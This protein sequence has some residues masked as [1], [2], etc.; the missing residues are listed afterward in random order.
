MH[1]VSLGTGR[2]LFSHLLWQHKHNCVS[3]LH[4]WSP[5]T[6]D[7]TYGPSRFALAQEPSHGWWQVPATCPLW[8]LWE[9][10]MPRTAFLPGVFCWLLPSVKPPLLIMCDSACRSVHVRVCVCVCVFKHTPSHWQWIRAPTSQ[11]R[12]LFISCLAGLMIPHSFMTP[13]CCCYFLIIAKLRIFPYVSQPFYVFPLLISFARVFLVCWF[14]FLY[15]F[16][17]IYILGIILSAV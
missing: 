5:K 9:E 2:I 15:Q 1:P 14:S 13:Q 7:S 4:T 3:S 6:W 11:N 10:E 12:L 8:E 17:G 16:L